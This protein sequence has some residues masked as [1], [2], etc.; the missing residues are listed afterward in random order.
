MEL[1]PTDSAL[2]VE[3]KFKPMDIA[4]ITK[5]LPAAVKLD[6]FDYSIYGSLKGNVVYISPDT[7]MERTQAGDSFY[8]RVHILIDEAALAQRNLER[9]GKPVEI[10]PG[11]TATV[12]IQTGSQTVLSY[13]TKPI[14]K[15]LNTSLGER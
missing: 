14:T 13:F 9:K 5:D 7:L 12:E 10:Q 1:L 6:A 15:T 8:Y 3:A 2:I 11:M 4:F